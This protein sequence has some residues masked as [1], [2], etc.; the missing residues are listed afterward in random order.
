MVRPK[1]VGTMGNGILYARDPAFYLAGFNLCA[2]KRARGRT[3][4]S[5]HFGDRY[6]SPHI[7]FEDGGTGELGPRKRG[8]PIIRTD[9]R[10]GS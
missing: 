3:G 6:R 2:A 9:V 7:R 10:F 1:M 5:G 4:N 8:R